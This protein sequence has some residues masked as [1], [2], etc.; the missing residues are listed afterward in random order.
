MLGLIMIS[1][2]GAE[3]V[4]EP[5]G[6]SRVRLREHLGGLGHEHEQCPDMPTSA[7]PR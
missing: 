1:P 6:A 4:F 5:V 2:G 3:H 7:D